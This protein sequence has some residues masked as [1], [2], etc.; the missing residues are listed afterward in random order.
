MRQPYRHPY[1]VAVQPVVIGQFGVER[2]REDPALPQQHG[3]AGEA[4]Q[5]FD[6]GA[7]GIEA[8]RPDEDSAHGPRRAADREIGLERI[9]LRTVGIAPHGRIEQSE[10]GLGGL[11][12]PGQ[13][14]RSGAGAEDGP[15]AGGEVV[16]PWKPRL[17]LHQVQQRRAL[18]SGDDEPLHLVELGNPANL[19][20]RHTDARKRRSV[21][22]KIALERQKPDPHAHP[23][24]PA[25]AATRSR[26]AH[27]FRFRPSPRRGSARLRPPSPGP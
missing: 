11:H 9:D 5:H 2:S 3:L 7:H 24:N 8:R 19:G 1:E 20:G 6:L 23:T 26:A 15:A 13:E 14:D 4:G 22:S 27:G 10:A 12:A 17:V 25:S 21:R 18:A 16:Q